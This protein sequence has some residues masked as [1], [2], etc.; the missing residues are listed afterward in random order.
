MFLRAL[1][2]SILILCTVAATLPL[3]DSLA[4]WSNKPAAARRYKGRYSR[5]H[6]R[7][8]WRRYRARLRRQRA[9]A[10][11][12]RRRRRA[13]MTAKNIS[14]FAPANHAAETAGNL[15][16]LMLSAVSLPS[17]AALSSITPVKPA[18]TT[19]I[20]PASKEQ[21]GL[22]VLPLPR[23]WSGATAN[24]AG[25]MRFNVRVGDGRALGAAIWSRVGVQP[26]VSASADSRGKS[27]GGVPVAV[28]RRI[29]I[30]RMVAEGG[31]VT[32]D[33]QRQFGE[34]RVFIVMAQSVAANGERRAQA[35]YFTES[36]GQIYSLAT[37]AP[38]AHADS[39]AAEFEQAVVALGSRRANSAAAQ[40]QR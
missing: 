7:A 15:N 29:V 33:L 34:R 1:V 14:P 10:A 31:W 6:S 28:L 4:H 32:N 35:F 2:L 16:S 5:R 18:A 24:R 39:L 30:D 13:L 11:E 36:D 8:W 25:E 38:A 3:T 40:F 21:L 17:T 9:V 23:G 20:V 12:R 26:V 27:F 37:N 22:S 19:I